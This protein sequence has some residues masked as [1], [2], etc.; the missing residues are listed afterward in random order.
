L[1]SEF[2]EDA[3]I[4]LKQF[5]FTKNIGGNLLLNSRNSISTDITYR[6][7]HLN[8]I[9]SIEY[10][11]FENSDLIGTSTR[12]DDEKNKNNFF[13]VSSEY[14]L[15]LNE[16]G[17][18][19]KISLLTQFG[20]ERG[21]SS[22][23]ESNIIPVSSILANDFIR[24][25]VDDNRYNFA[26]DYVNTGKDSSQY[27]LGFRN[28]N[29]TILN[30]FSVE[31]TVNNSS[32]LIPEFTDKTSYK[33]NVTAFYSQYAKT[34][35]KFQFQIG[36]RSETTH[37]KIRS[38]NNTKATSIR[39][40]D[41]FPSSFF[42]FKINDKN[43]LRLSFSRRI[44]RPRRNTIMSFN[45]FSDSR[46]VFAGNPDINPSYVVL[47][48]LGYQT[49]IGKRLSIT[50]TL[51]Y[52]NRKDVMDFYIQNETITFNGIPQNV[53]VTRT[54]NIGNSNSL[55]LEVSTSYKPLNWLRIYNELT[56]AYFEQTGTVNGVEYNS[57]GTFGYGRLN[58]N[59]TLSKTTKFQMQHRFS[60]GRTRG[61]IER[62]N[63]YR[64]DLGLSQSLF[65]G[66]ASLTLNM[67]DVFDT[68]EWHITQQGQDFI[69]NIDKQVRT[70]QFNVSFIYRFNQSKYKGKKGR[71]Y[72]RI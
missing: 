1:E 61:Q 16:R 58:L 48:E 57:D 10:Q 34:Y 31:R 17:S 39:Y 72:D 13:Q 50:P 22:I 42:D 3:E 20:S 70:P 14:R 63:L 8:N 36:L 45:S 27:E 35:K 25:D 49:K 44:Q 30:D 41:L 6:I 32:T 43:S 18:Q 28:R 12:I 23:L 56:L 26:I 7:A 47:A 33:E 11:D 51:F 59:F 21:E 62:K 2:H 55:G 67:K 66:N 54:V 29:T 24:N 71:Q 53:L 38:N 19:L 40:T 60:K 64:M 9:N 46:N 68:W 65:K 37:I 4:I 52:K 15:K 69:Q 5:Y